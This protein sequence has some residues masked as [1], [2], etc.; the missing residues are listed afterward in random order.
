ML[1]NDDMLRTYYSHYRI[2]I[3]YDTLFRWLLT[4]LCSQIFSCKIVGKEN[5]LTHRKP[6]Q[7]AADYFQSDLRYLSARDSLEMQ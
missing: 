5:R 7:T 6:L 2:Y 4:I 1:K 3:F